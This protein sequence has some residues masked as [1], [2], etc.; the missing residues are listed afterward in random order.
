MAMGVGIPL[1]E[2]KLATFANKYIQ[3][4]KGDKFSIFTILRN[5]F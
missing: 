3:F 1:S 5:V 2:V 4:L